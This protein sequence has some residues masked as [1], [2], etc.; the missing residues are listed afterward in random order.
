MTDH[1]NKI[2]AADKN[3]NDLLKDQKFF[4]DY[5][6]REYRWQEKHMTTLIEDL[7]N[8]FLKSYKKEDKRSD[9]A[10]YQSYYLGPVVF[11]IADGKN[12][13]IDGQQRITSITLFLIYL[14][15]LQ[16]NSTNQ[17]NIE[18]L[19]FS[20][21]YG[22][23]SFNMT[24]QDRQAV[25]KGLFDNE[26]Y[27]LKNLDDETVHNIVGRYNDIHNVFPEELTTHALPYFIDWF[28]GN[29]VLVKITAYSDENAYTIFETMNDRGMNI[30]AT[31]MLKGY[32]LSRISNSVERSEI[33]QLWKNHIK[34]LHEL[35]SNADLDF[36]KAWFRA[37]YAVTVRPR[38]ADSE[39]QDYEQIG[40][41]LHDWFKNNH[42][43]KFNLSNS[44]HFFEFFINE[45][46]YFIKAYKFIWEKS[47]QYDS[48]CP[49]LFYINQWGIAASLQ[50]ALLLAPLKSSDSDE[51]LVK[52][53]DAVARFVETFTVRR[54]V[55]FMKFGSS[56]IQY[57]IF[58]IIKNIR[59]LDLDELY[60]E[61]TKELHQLD[62]DF[63]AIPNFRL[64]QQNKKFVKHLLCRITAFVD[65]SVGRDNNYVNYKDPQGKPFE[66]EH[67]WSNSFDDH[68]DE[69]DQEWEFS[70]VRNSIGA[71]ILL[72]NG[73]NQS[74]N[75]DKYEDKLPH[76][77]KENT[78]AQTLHP[79][80]YH[81]N[82]NFRNSA[83]KSIPFKAHPQL[84]SDDI[85]ERIKVVQ[86]L[87]EQ[88]WSTD[89]YSNTN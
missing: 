48:Q 25:L 56:S 51:I 35:N 44:S 8:A 82:P 41:R 87:C 68:R 67:L 88:I 2:E 18:N 30:T 20:E 75:S 12:S 55:N 47:I 54:S 52:K 73:T 40:T 79:D 3:I 32:V 27:N 4:I 65:Q 17:V 60:K 85:K 5:F 45:F 81:K 33:N 74:F 58:N 49:H 46:D 23:K 29:V 21:K 22:E 6:Q 15:H 10:N 69:F 13:I 43:D 24:D 59:N 70:D 19:V 71:L 42:T 57:T 84:Y 80:F 64:H 78:Y 50:D 11:S 39:N 34:D 1:K 62:Q 76:Y 66:I 9:V 77:L 26:E 37:K 89:H 83:L 61:L 7:A 16:K 31:E 53:M 28:I 36:F 38:K 72:P 63:G 14:N 86:S